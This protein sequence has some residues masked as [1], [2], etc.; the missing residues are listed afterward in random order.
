MLRPA[1]Y[2]LLSIAAA[3]ML[4][5]CALQN[6]QERPFVDIL[7][8]D[9]LVFT[10]AEGRAGAALDVGIAGNRIVFVGDA[11]AEGIA[12]Q[13]TIDATGLIVA[14]GFI[15]PHTHALDDLLSESDSRN[16]NYLTQGVTTV[17]AGNDGGGPVEIGATLNTLQNNRIGPN[18]GLFVG[19]NSVR[20]AVMGGADREPRPQE[21]QRMR[22]L[23]RDGMTQGA[24]GLSAGLY[25]APGSFAKTDELVE[26]ARVAAEF[27]GVYESHLRDESSYSVGLLMA[28]EEA[29]EIGAKSGAPV[30]IAH[31]KALGVDVWGQS[32]DVIERV[33]TAR[34][35]GQA[36]TADQ[37]PWAASGTRI[38]N[39]LIP[40][41]AKAGSVEDMHDRLRDPVLQSRIRTEIEENLRKRG[42][43]DALLI[44]AGDDAWVGETLAEIA[45][46]RQ[47]D[48]AATAVAIVL[49]GDAR[50]ASF[51]M[52][53]TDIEAFM[54]Q[55]WVATSSDGTNGH[56]RK[57][58]SFPRKYRHY[59]VDKKILSLGQFIRRSTGLTADI[60]GLCGRGYIREGYAADIVVFDPENF[61]ETATYSEPR[62]LSLGVTH[63]F[64]NGAAVIS[65]E[66]VNDVY[67]G[68]PLRRQRCN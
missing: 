36:V 61:R 32:A 63:L 54:K 5:A 18:T 8:A 60:F 6:A 14:P 48:V 27:G 35:N 9:G 52:R 62:A 47:E 34:R 49:D 28:V 7:I 64:V 66:A 40:N 1:K 13:T 11:Q 30:H 45:H 21:L 68:A 19:H 4:C 33:E 50:V 24:F 17:L 55:P 43:A 3:L 25:Y 41:W 42:G 38:S 46:N 20:E 2:I 29:L 31:I 22:A 51:N 67:A 56:P 23:V 37:Y 44:V 57:Y 10:G 12:A 53:E 65:H 39:A 26:L 59:V 15:D 58:G 16:V